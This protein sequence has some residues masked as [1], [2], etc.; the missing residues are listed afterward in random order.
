MPIR[1]YS[2]GM[3]V[4]LALSI[5]TAIE[6]EIFIV[7]E[8]LS[9]GDLAFQTKAAARIRAMMSQARLIVMV[10]HDLESLQ[11][12]STRILWMDHGRAKM[13]GPP[14]EVI[15]AYQHHA[16]APA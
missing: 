7:D 3:R 16:L 9:V 4:R 12:L 5:A 8:V 6:P 10:S 14:A 15:R 1:S 11:S 2:A 13:E